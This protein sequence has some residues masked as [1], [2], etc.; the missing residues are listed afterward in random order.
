MDTQ[1]PIHTME[2]LSMPERDPL[3]ADRRETY[4]H[5][6]S[7]TAPQHFTTRTADRQAA[8]FLPHLRPRMRLL[9]CG[10]GPGTITLGLAEV[11]APGEAV[12]I[13]IIEGQLAQARQ[14]ASSR[15]LTNARFKAASVYALPFDDES[16]DAVFSNAVLGH[17][18]DPAAALAEMKR[19]LRPGGVVGIRNI[20]IDG[21]IYVPETTLQ[22]KFRDLYKQMLAVNGGNAQIGRHHKALLRETGFDVVRASAM[23]EVYSSVEAVRHWGMVISGLWA[24]ASVVELV[25]RNEF[26]SHAEMQALSQDWRDWSEHPDAFFADAWFEAVGRRPG[27]ASTA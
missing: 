24:E 17:L 25:T 27:H 6:E 3:A 15:G 1:Q 8:F 5:H 20:D 7:E 2:D 13:D 26:A 12:G 23:Y 16:F 14:E 9:D 21:Q 10:C 19:V 4:L 22:R 18:G 11:V